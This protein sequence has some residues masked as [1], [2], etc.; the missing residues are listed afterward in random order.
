VSVR[1]AL[2]GLA[3]V[4]PALSIVSGGPAVGAC[5]ATVARRTPA[6]V[7]SVG[8]GLDGHLRLV[9]RERISHDGTQVTPGGRLVTRLGR[10]VPIIRG[11]V[12]LIT[13]VG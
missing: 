9:L 4:A 10:T 12:V 5:V 7:G 11:P 2:R 3:F 8:A 13:F 6:V 1:S